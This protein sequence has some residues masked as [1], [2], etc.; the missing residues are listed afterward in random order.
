MRAE[1]Y[2]VAPHSGE[3]IHVQVHG[4]KRGSAPM[5]QRKQRW[6]VLDIQLE[7]MAA[8]NLLL[9]AVVLIF[10]RIDRERDLAIAR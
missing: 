8:M 9:T 5:F 10:H 4:N 7:P 6:P 3:R 1:I 2:A